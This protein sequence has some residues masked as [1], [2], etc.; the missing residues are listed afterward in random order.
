MSIV[1][2]V[3]CA[4]L[5]RHEVILVSLIFTS[6]HLEAAADDP[7][8]ANYASTVS[9]DASNSISAIGQALGNSAVSQPTQQNHTLAGSAAPIQVNSTLTASWHQ[10]ANPFDA[11]CAVRASLRHFVGC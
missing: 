2:I 10:I 1:A 4:M 9:D 7:T 3:G 5:T 11:T 8:S 6:L